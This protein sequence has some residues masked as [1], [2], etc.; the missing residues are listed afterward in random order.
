MRQ[1]LAETVAHTAGGHGARACL[2]ASGMSR[3]AVM[4]SLY[5]L[6]PQELGIIPHI[7]GMSCQTIMPSRSAW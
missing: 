2:P 6:L 1:T 3:S 4:H 7:D 5:Q